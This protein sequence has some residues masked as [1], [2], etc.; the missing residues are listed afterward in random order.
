MN[1][2]EYF[3]E[4]SIENISKII[5]E[6]KVKKTFLVTGKKSFQSSGAEKVFKNILKDTEVIHFTDFSENP[7]L[8]DIEEGIKK[9]RE[10]DSDIVI[11]IGGGSVIDVAKL[12][13][14]LSSQSE[15]PIN[16]ITGN[17]EILKKGKTLI[18]LPTT[19]GSGSEATHFAVVYR[20]R[21][22]YSVANKSILPDISII[23]PTLTYNLPPLIT[24]A[25]GIDALSQAI[26]S[27]W[28]VNSNEESIKL[29]E[30]AIKII[31]K[32]LASAVN[33]PSAGNR[34]AMSRA[35][36]L[37]GKAINITK[38]TAPHAVSY[39]MTS[40][41][42]VTHGQAVSITLKEFLKY[43]YEVNESDLT[44]KRGV[45]HVKSSIERIIKI[46]DC[47]NTDEAA[48]RITELM[49]AVGLK[50]RLSDLN[51]ESE[52]DLKIIK[53]NINYQRL[54]NNPRQV[55]KEGLDRILRNIL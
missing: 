22:K 27:H 48:N 47:K 49:N 10:S 8:E 5:S 21:D 30:E 13:N 1:Q 28:C 46:M 6:R 50:I 19:S 38:T 52:E 33:D 25:S 55:S 20:N 12:I 51:I 34:I 18:A 26:E 44:D 31:F 9:F 16:Y 53:E 37:A 54:Q 42:G 40:Y 29:S 43:N 4:G 35:S 15:D 3:G 11:A 32:N 2:E 41:F 14:T 24:A 39:S 7:K 17:A 23:D 36:N 45:D